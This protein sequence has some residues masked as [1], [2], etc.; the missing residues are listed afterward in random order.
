MNQVA[1]DGVVAVAGRWRELPSC[2][3]Q[4]E[5]E[6]ISARIL[7]PIDARLPRC[8]F[9]VF[10]NAERREDLNPRVASVNLQRHIRMPDQ[11]LL[12]MIDACRE[13]LEQIQQLRS[14]L[15]VRPNDVTRVLETRCLVDRA[16]GNGRHE[17]A[18]EQTFTRRQ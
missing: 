6:Q 1:A 5:G 18:N 8:D 10:A 17:H 12:N 7:R 9:R 3:V 13:D 14:N 11:S 2:L 16:V 15:R 4:R